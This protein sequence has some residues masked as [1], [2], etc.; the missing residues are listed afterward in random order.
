MLGVTQKCNHNKCIFCE[1][2]YSNTPTNDVAD[3]IIEKLKPIFPHLTYVTLAG[4]GEPLAYPKFWELVKCIREVNP[5][6]SI[7]T[8]TNGITIK[9]NLNNFFK[10][11]FTGLSV[12]FNGSSKEIYEDI[13]NYPF[14]KIK[15]QLLAM[16]RAKQKRK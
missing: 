12:S 2:A 6:C 4:W 9:Q 8:I 7:D 3:F 10:Y 5:K 13:M 11:N 1:K 16:K 15:S 14:E